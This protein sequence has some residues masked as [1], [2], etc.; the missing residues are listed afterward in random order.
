METTYPYH[1]M[2]MKTSEFLQLQLNGISDEW[3]KFVCEYS[4]QH[5]N[6]TTR[7]YA[8]QKD[9]TYR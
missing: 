4:K 5:G 8:I 6:Q 3:D 2:K 7:A 1:Q 9:A